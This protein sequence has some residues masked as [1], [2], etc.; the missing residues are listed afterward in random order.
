MQLMWLLALEVLVVLPFVSTLFLLE[1]TAIEPA[2]V[3]ARP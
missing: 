1:R 3:D 2:P